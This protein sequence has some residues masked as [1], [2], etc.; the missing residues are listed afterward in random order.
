MAYFLPPSMRTLSLLICSIASLSLTACTRK[1]VDLSPL[2]GGE[3]CAGHYTQYIAL[4]IQPSTTE[5]GTLTDVPPVPIR[6]TQQQF[7]DAGV[8][9]NTLSTDGH[10]ITITDAYHN[11][12]PFDI[13][14][15]DAERGYVVW[16]KLPEF[17]TDMGM[18]LLVYLGNKSGAVR[19]NPD[20]WDSGFMGVWHLA[21]T[22]GATF[23]DATGKGNDAVGHQATT[24]S[25]SMGAG[26]S[27]SADTAGL[28]ADGVAISGG[29]SFTIEGWFS[30][31]GNAYRYR[32]PLIADVPEDDFEVLWQVAD[33]PNSGAL[34][35]LDNLATVTMVDDSN[36]PLP[37]QVITDTGHGTEFWYRVLSATTHES[38][39]LYGNPNPPER[40]SL[41]T[42]HFYARDGWFEQFESDKAAFHDA[43]KDP[44]TNNL[45][46]K[47]G[48]MW[49]SLG[50]VDQPLDIR[51]GYLIQTYATTLGGIGGVTPFIASSATPDIAT[52]TTDSFVV[53]Q[54]Q[55][56]D[57]VLFR[58]A[59]GSTSDGASD[60]SKDLSPISGNIG[61]GIYEGN[62]TV[63]ANN[64]QLPGMP[65]TGNWAN[66][67]NT[68]I[69][70]AYDASNSAPFS[71]TT[72][73][74]IMIYKWH[75]QTVTAALGNERVNG[76]S[77]G[78]FA[79]TVDQK[80][81]DISASGTITTLQLPKS[82]PAHHIA[83]VVTNTTY[84]AFVDGQSVATG[85]TESFGDL[86]G[87]NL[88]D[89]R[90]LNGVLDEVRISNVARSADWLA[91]EERSMKSDFMEVTGKVMTLP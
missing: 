35:S 89:G 81:V 9:P 48:R 52:P 21:E 29:A 1:S 68:L 58:T 11:V 28:H 76:L 33:L 88:I 67:L 37:Y 45:T 61:V 41:D 36:T 69:I 90:A 77:L 55:S 16:V 22:E 79:I 44:L 87:F 24:G 60:I 74:R 65:Q 75:G 91:F 85:T 13:E 8:D 80:N 2:C 26:Q 18:S 15:W 5:S 17:H 32:R 59:A 73:H 57:T 84:Q 12:R 23:V 66:E 53:I 54:P 7:R 78:N 38:A 30:V 70:G 64:E 31:T 56:A 83:L 51:K 27:M 10:D 86:H 14:S 63:F 49:A 47:T 62:V 40:S 34:L 72:Y 25:G 82:A 3:I 19:P 6:L 71:Q 4:T 42:F 43:G 50:S 46:M 20:V 39:L